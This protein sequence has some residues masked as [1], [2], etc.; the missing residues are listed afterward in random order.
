MFPS[1]NSNNRLVK[2]L[3][4]KIFSDAALPQDQAMALCLC[5]RYLHCFSYLLAAVLCAP[6][7]VTEAN[8]W[9]QG[10]TSSQEDLQARDIFSVLKGEK[11]N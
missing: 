4:I 8:P 1:V 5:T 2:L 11:I 3:S 6:V 10:V 9:G 7:I